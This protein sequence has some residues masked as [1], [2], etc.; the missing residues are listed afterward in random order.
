MST[1]QYDLAYWP[2][3]SHLPSQTSWIVLRNWAHRDVW[4]DGCVLA[5]FGECIMYYRYYEIDQ[6]SGLAV[7][8]CIRWPCTF[9]S[10]T[11][12]F[13]N[14]LYSLMARGRC[15]FV[16]FYLFKFW[17]V[18]TQSSM[19]IDLISPIK[20]SV[21]HSNR[22]GLYSVNTLPLQILAYLPS[23]EM[24]HVRYV[25]YLGVFSRDGAFWNRVK[26]GGTTTWICPI[27]TQIIVLR[28]KPFCYGV[29]CWTRPR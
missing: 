17:T 18:A 19:Q 1:V 3:Y 11:T 4:Y 6:M 23:K 15:Y 26:Q 14:D 20:A 28:C 24:S 2:C 29:P 10:S 25:D 7:E 5:V 13:L 22:N 8:S 12:R 9:F 16:M 21:D 27:K